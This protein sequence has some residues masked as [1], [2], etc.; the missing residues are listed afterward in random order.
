MRFELVRIA[1][2]E[3]I[4][5][6]SDD[7]Q[8]APREHFEQR[9]SVV[10]EVRDVD[11][12]RRDLLEK[13]IEH[14]RHVR[15]VVRVLDP[16]IG[17]AILVDRHDRYALELVALQQLCLRGLAGE[18]GGDDHRRV[19]QSAQVPRKIERVLLRPVEVGGEEAVDEQCD[20]HARYGASSWYRRS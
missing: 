17:Q 7:G 19:T 10:D 12:V 15:L 11:D 5:E 14:R 2:A 1:E 6:R 13:R 20:L 9:G 16:R 4:G 8:R 3:E 18:H